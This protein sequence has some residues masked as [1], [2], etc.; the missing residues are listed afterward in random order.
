MFTDAPEELARVVLAQ[1]GAD[2]RVAALETGAGALERV[3]SRLG[4]GAT[5]VRTSAE[6]VELGA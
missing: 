3:R 6:L 1:L 5:V 2:R 4:E